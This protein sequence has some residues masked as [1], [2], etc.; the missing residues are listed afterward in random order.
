MRRVFVEYSNIGKIDVNKVSRNMI[1][2]HFL[3]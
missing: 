3:L 1:G 2:L